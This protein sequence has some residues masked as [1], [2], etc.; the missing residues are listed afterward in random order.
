MTWIGVYF[1]LL[2]L[3]TVAA[4]LSLSGVHLHFQQRCPPAEW[5]L[6]PPTHIS[7]DHGAGIFT[8]KLGDF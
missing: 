8:T 6:I 5:C 3:L 2:T 4:D 1:T 7:E